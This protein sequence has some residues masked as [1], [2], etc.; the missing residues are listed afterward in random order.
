[1]RPKQTQRTTQTRR[2]QIG[3]K[4]LQADR[5]SQA[6]SSTPKRSRK[7]IRF[8]RFI[9]PKFAAALS[10]AVI[11]FAV[12]GF[13]AVQFYAGQRLAAQDTASKQERAK[14]ISADACRRQKAEQKADLI[15]KVTYDELY[16]GDECD[17]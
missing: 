10:V 11:G 7:N 5:L 13:G 1:M 16:D 17:K 14:S 2:R 4:V 6:L 9:Q 15:G 12:I 3:R 8:T